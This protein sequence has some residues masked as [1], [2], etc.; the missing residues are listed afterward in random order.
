MRPNGSSYTPGRCTRWSR[1]NS[2]VP[3][4]LPVPIARYQAA[5]WRRIAGTW[6]RVSTLLTVVGRPATPETPG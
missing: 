1:V 2:M 3:V 6:A 4:L 5:P